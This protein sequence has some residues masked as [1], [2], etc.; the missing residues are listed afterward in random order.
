MRSGFKPASRTDELDAKKRVVLRD[1]LAARRCTSLDLADTEGDDEVS[2]EG[3]LGL[4]GTVGD[5]DTP[6]V[7]LAELGTRND[8]RIGYLWVWGGRTYAWMDS[9]MVPIWLT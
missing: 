4:T 2:D 9:E 3:V 8:I 6:S 7:R 1:T 5:H